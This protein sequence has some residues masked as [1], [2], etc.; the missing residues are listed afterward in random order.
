[1]SY[2]AGEAPRVEA[3]VLLPEDGRLMV[4]VRGELA[5]ILRLSG[6]ANEKAPAS[7]PEL[8]PEQIKMV[9]GACYDLN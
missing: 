7:R 6:C 9:E 5:A 3:I 4:E 1:M 2:A 8:L